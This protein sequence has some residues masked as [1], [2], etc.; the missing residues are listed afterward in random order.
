MNSGTKIKSF[1]EVTRLI[2]QAKKQGFTVVTTNGVFDILHVGHVRYLE[3]AKQLGDLLVVGINTNRSVKMN[4]GPSRPVI[5]ERERASMVAALQMVDYVFLFSDKTPSR[6][7][8]KLKPHIHV[9]GG[10]RKL[11]QIVERS[12]LK[13]IGARLVLVPPIK[14][15]STTNILK[16]IHS[17]KML[18]KLF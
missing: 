16:K 4:K 8:K 12:V 14:N 9:K 5:P 7:L 18:T 11:S 17:A 15:K 3:R 2:A 10:D 1:R 6:W 13:K